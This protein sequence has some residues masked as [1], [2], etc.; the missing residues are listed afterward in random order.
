[1]S[2]YPSC[3]N[4]FST[5]F[6][7]CDAAEQLNKYNFLKQKLFNY[8][9]LSI[10]TI[11]PTFREKS[12]NYPR[13]DMFHTPKKVDHVPL[14]GCLSKCGVSTPPPMAIKPHKQVRSPFMWTNAW[15]WAPA[16]SLSLSKIQD[17]FSGVYPSNS[18]YKSY[19]PNLYN[20]NPSVILPRP[21]RLSESFGS[22][23]CLDI[24][25]TNRVC[26]GQWDG[27]PEIRSFD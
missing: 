7:D 9:Q 20:R 19:L 24:C 3:Y 4:T 8:P 2:I 27:N 16:N 12:V 18:T 17:F 13:K 25:A 22:G 26:L 1:M 15:C 21:I 11:S 23:C 6:F 5:D 14:H 10:S